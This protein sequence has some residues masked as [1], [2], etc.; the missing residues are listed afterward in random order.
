MKPITVSL[1]TNCQYN[2]NHTPLIWEWCQFPKPT[3]KL[4]W[5]D[6]TVCWSVW[7]NL[8][9]D[10]HVVQRVVKPVT[11]QQTCSIN[12]T[13]WGTLFGT[14]LGSRV[15]QGNGFIE[16]EALNCWSSQQGILSLLS[17]LLTSWSRV[18]PKT[19]IVFQLVKIF[20]AFYGNRR[21]VT[22]FTRARHWSLSW[23]RCIQSTPSH[24]ISLRFIL[25][26]S[27]PMVSS[28]RTFQPKLC[29]HLSSLPYVLHVPSISSSWLDHTIFDEA[30][31]LLSSSLSSL[32][33]RPITCS[34]LTK[35]HAMKAYWE[36]GGIAPLI[37]WSRH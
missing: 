4:T 37:L 19:L 17:V 7:P 25:M 21:F 32:L 5:R 30:Y 24:P 20:A 34:S 31:N 8:T 22:V 33:R 35:H 9:S 15:V 6:D 36:S 10:L 14:T 23:A 3:L 18:L 1:H 29:I 26:L 2:C 11:M 13:D 28:L 27:F 12:C 16:N